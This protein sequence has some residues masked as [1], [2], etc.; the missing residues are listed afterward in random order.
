VGTS[1]YELVQ[2]EKAHVC[3]NFQ[4]VERTQRGRESEARS[5]IRSRALDDQKRDYASSNDKNVQGVC[6][7]FCY[8]TDRWDLNVLYAL[9]V[10]GHTSEGRDGKVPAEP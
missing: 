10:G 7:A 3:E 5:S 2:W 4:L 1:A 9:R 6:K 8:D